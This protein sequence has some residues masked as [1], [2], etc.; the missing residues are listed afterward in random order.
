VQSRNGVID[1]LV[2]DEV[3]AVKVGKAVPFVLSRGFA[4]R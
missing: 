1:V 4:T 3:Q 2:D